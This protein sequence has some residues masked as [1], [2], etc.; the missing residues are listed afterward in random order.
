MST[1]RSKVGL[2]LSGGGYRAAAFHLGT[3]RKL[4]SLGTLEQVDVISTI[5]GGSITGAY[6]CL[7]DNFEEFDR[8]LYEALQHK[9]VVTKVLPFTFCLKGQ[10]GYS[11]FCWPCLYFY[12]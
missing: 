2:S 7:K 12:C 11:R 9:N 10:P 8:Q 1:L 6:Y 4:H 3:I 5:S